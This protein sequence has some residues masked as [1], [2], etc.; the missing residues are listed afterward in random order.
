MR[1]RR[2]ERASQRGIRLLEKRILG[3]YSKMREEKRERERKIIE[4]REGKR[5][6]DQIS[7][8]RDPRRRKREIK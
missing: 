2:R 8:D 3:K 7:S 6:R 1:E 5:E 4:S